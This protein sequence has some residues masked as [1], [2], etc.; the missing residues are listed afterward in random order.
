MTVTYMEVHGG[1]G[2]KSP[3][4]PL[5][6]TRDGLASYCEARWPVGRRKS[7]AKEW[8]LS[9]D[10]AR[11]ICEGSASQ[12]TL[13][14]IWRHKRGGWAVLLP[15]MGA[16]IGQPIHEFF[17][18]QNE[19]AAREASVALEHERLA[20]TAYRALADDASPPGE[21]RRSWPRPG[22]VGAH[23]ARRVAGD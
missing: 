20:R 17:R 13:D 23:E 3:M 7:I 8:D 10:E 16:V 19:R 4:F 9:A 6:R 11:S 12:M 2:E 14:K 15:V 22:E 18:A 5:D 1:F 21:D